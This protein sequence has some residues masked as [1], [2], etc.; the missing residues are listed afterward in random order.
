MSLVLINPIADAAREGVERIRAK[1]SW[2]LMM[3]GGLWLGA[4][5]AGSMVMLHY[6]ESPGMAAS[7]PV[8]WPSGSGIPQDPARSNLVL[9]VH[10][11]CPCS[12]ATIGELALLMAQSQGQVKAHVWFLRPAGM[13]EEWTKTDLW[14][15]AAAIPGVQVHTD[16][17]GVEASR[18]RAKTSGQT[19]LYD[20]DGALMFQG[21]ITLARGHSG[22]N[23][24]RSAVTAMLDDGLLGMVKTPV[25]G[26][27]LAES[28]CQQ[29]GTACRR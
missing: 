27:A 3:A 5:V 20:R 15:S 25:F 19:V 2:L 26:C 28:E 12:R 11:H 21:G 10:P 9:F 7:A 6:A 1:P 24:G 16:E 23:P 4:I 8:K 14:E 29:G 13:T 17:A 18:F 22:D